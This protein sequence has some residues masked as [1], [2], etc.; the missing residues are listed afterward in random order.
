MAAV[1]AREKKELEE[2]ANMSVAEI[3]QRRF[4]HKIKVN[5]ITSE[6]GVQDFIIKPPALSKF[7]DVEATK[8]S[9]PKLEGEKP[10][11]SKAAEE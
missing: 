4:K 3:I 1:I 5:N 9:P 8:V 7:Q 2:E 10:A 6:Q 11:A